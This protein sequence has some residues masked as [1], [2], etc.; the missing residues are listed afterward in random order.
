MMRENFRQWLHRHP[1]YG[2]QCRAWARL[3]LLFLSLLLFTL[4]SAALFEEAD[5]GAMTADLQKRIPVL[6]LFPSW[7]VTLGI[8]FSDWRYFRHML[9]PLAAVM[10]VL[11]AGGFYIRNI[12][13]I[14]AISPA[15]H[16]L[17]SSMFGVGYP[18]LEI[19][20]GKTRI[21]DGEINPV[22]SIG[23]PGFVLI[24]PGNAVIFRDL[25]KPSNIALPQQYF[26]RPFEM[27]GTIADLDEQHGY[28]KEIRA[29]THDGIQLHIRDINYRYK[30]LADKDENGGNRTR[31]TQNPYPFSIDAMLDMAYN[32]SVSEQGPETWQQAVQRT[33]NG[34]ITDFISVNDIDYLTAPRRDGEDPRRELRMQLFT[35]NIGSLL[36]RIG[37]ELL[38]IDAGHFDIDDFPEALEEGVDSQRFAYWAARWIGND[39]KVRAIGNAQRI[40]YQE[41]G[42]AEAQAELLKGITESLQGFDLKEDPAA[43]LRKMLLVRTAQ[44][45]EGMS[46][47]KSWKRD[48]KL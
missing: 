18:T 17:F 26:M 25:R 8:P 33:V 13:D 43:N 40:A 31:S 1:Y 29:V 7:I 42:R 22:A 12:H 41:K 47:T 24:Q 23:G 20:G 37:A 6:R 46:E 39:N 45:L 35:D 30:L 9:A 2:E 4:L 32:N 14:P 15:F 38:W 44:I 34:G 21:D 19:D 16:Y 28:E 36:R 11:I 10:L 48:D 27:I 3:I 5:L